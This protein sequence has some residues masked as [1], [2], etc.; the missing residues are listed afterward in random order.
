M[1]AGKLWP[2]GETWAG[3]LPRPSGLGLSNLRNN[4]KQ[5]KGGGGITSHGR[6]TVRQGAFL[7][8]D[9]VG[10][11]DLSFLTC[12]LPGTTM[13]Q[14]RTA[15]EKWGEVT[16]RFLQEIRRELQRHNLPDWIIGCTEI[17]P[18]RFAATG[19]PW[20][21]L[22]IVFP[23]RANRQWIIRPARANLL[24]A[25][26]CKAVLGGGLGDYLAATRIEQIKSSKPVG[27]YLAK[28]MSKGG[29]ELAAILEDDPEFPH[30]AQ[31]H[32]VTH[33]L[34]DLIAKGT[35]RLLGDTAAWIIRLFQE[36]YP[37]CKLFSLISPT[38]TEAVPHDA[39]MGYFGMLDPPLASRV[40]DYDNRKRGNY[41]H[42]IPV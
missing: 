34:G 22:H 24:W 21:H 26:C 14:C 3:H 6:R 33:A 32:H 42:P 1:L 17:Q 20:P 30:P 41:D 13:E 18:K 9:L 7:L 29:D 4:H 35:K 37:G 8:E 5:P 36:G 12:T 16:R 31:W 19:Q 10:K 28:Y 2:N 23:G 11:D 40:I 38:P 39:P 15:N 25:R 27:Q